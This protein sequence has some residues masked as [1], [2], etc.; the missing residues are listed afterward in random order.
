MNRIH[1]LHENNEWVEPLRVALRDRDLP[2]TEW[3]LDTGTLDLTVA[4]PDGVFY[5][6]MSASSHTRGHRF[7]PEHA[8]AVLAWLE[9]HG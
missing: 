5:N 9:R 2:F 6:R 7:A 8:A 1:I 3:F 4:P